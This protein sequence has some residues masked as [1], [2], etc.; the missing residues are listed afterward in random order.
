MVRLTVK[1]GATVVGA[2]AGVLVY[3]DFNDNTLGTNLGG[4]AGAMSYD[5]AHDPTLSFVPGYEGS[6]LRISYSVPAGQWCGYWSFFLASQKGY[7][8]SGFTDIRMWV[9]GGAGG[10]NFKIELKDF[11]GR[12][13]HVYVSI[14]PGF[15][16]GLS[17]S[18]QEL[19]IPLYNF[20]GV[21]LRWLRQVNIVFDTYPYSGTVYIDRIAFTELSPRTFAPLGLVLDDFNSGS[22]PNRLGGSSGTIDPNPDDPAEWITASYVTDS[23]EG[24]GALKLAYNR[25]T[26]SWVGYWTYM[27]PDGSGYDVSDYE[28]IS[29]YVKGAAGG[30]NFKIELVDTSNN[31]ATKYVTVP[32][33]SYQKVSLPFSQFSNIQNVNLRSLKQVNIVFDTSPNTGTVYI[34]LIRFEWVFYKEVAKRAFLYFWFEANPETGLV[35]D[36]NSDSMASIAATGFGLSAICV[37][38]NKGW[39][40]AQEA[41]QRVLT[42]LQFLRDNVQ[43]VNGMPY[44]FVWVH[45]GQRYGYSEIS[46][47]DT[48]IL[49]AGVLHA[50]NHFSDNSQIVSLAKELF[51]AVDWYWFVRPSGTFAAM[52]TPE[53]GFFGERF[54]YDEYMIAGILGLGSLTYP[55]PRSSWDAWRSAYQW[56]EYENYWFLCPAGYMRPCAYL[57][58]F[59]AAW[60]D[61]RDKHDNYVDYWEMMWNALAANR[62]YCRDWAENYP[63]YDDNL[64]GWTACEGPTGYLGWDPFRGTIAPSAVAGSL[65]FMPDNVIPDLWYI[66]EHYGDNIWSRYGFKDSMDSGYNSGAG[67]FAENSVGINKGPEVLLVEA[68]W[69]G[70]V[71]REFMKNFN[72]L[73]GLRK[74]GFTWRIY[75]SDDSYVDNTQPNTNFGTSP[76]LLVENTA[77]RSRLA[78]LKFDLSDVFSQDFGIA[79]ARLNVFVY[80]N[81]P[82]L[83]VVFSVENDAWSENTI[84]WNS[85]P[86]FQENIGNA[87]CSA[88]W[89]SIDITRWVKSQYGSDRKASVAVW[90]TQNSASLRS[91]EYT[92]NRK[93]RPFLSVRFSTVR[94]VVERLIPVADAYTDFNDPNTA[95]GVQN[96]KRLAVSGVSNYYRRSY[97]K[98]DTSS[99]P[100][101]AQILKARLWVY[102]NSVVNP[103]NPVKTIFACQLSNDAWQENTITWNNQPE[104][105]PAISENSSIPSSG[106]VSWDVTSWVLDQIS[107]DNVVSIV[108][109]TYEPASTIE[110]W[111]ESK[112]E[113]FGHIPYLEV[114]YVEEHVAP[115]PQSP[116]NN[117]K[118]FDN[119]PTFTWLPA[120]LAERHRLQIDNDP[121][122]TSPIYDN[123]NLSGSANQCTIENQLPADNYYWRVGA[124]VGGE[125]LWSGAMRLEIIESLSLILYPTH[126]AKVESAGP[127][128]NYNAQGLAA[129][130]PNPAYYRRSF[131]KF[132][133]SGI[134]PDGS[135][136]SAYLLLYKDGEGGGGDTNR[137][138]GAYRVSDDSWSETTITWNNQPSIGSLENY[139]LTPG[140]TGFWENWNVA[141]WADN[142]YKGDRILT[143]AIRMVDERTDWDSAEPYWRDREYSDA[144]Y[145]PRLVIT[146][147]QA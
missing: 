40:S 81:N 74:A 114:V 42:T 6:A 59:P 105:G 130:G 129:A 70:M 79:E 111:F 51:D 147:R 37:G 71:W 124:L 116:E 4:A 99:L 24:L 18:W 65:P 95:K 67:W 127:D 144:A 115:V 83:M 109:R 135:V 17:T 134:P 14:V 123:S 15:E 26:A 119:T 146:V 62:E 63:E 34:D 117:S 143:I 9:K 55:L 30:E 106:W 101:G 140:T 68:Y 131:L 43:K 113:L 139:I 87:T 8:V 64:W 29:F 3:D 98:F 23:Y 72:A 89:V 50:A 141:S 21:N 45:N 128:T 133:L 145:R 90:I 75:P 36:K 27:R 13:R 100:S 85:R 10:E 118:T 44:H 46:I 120:P 93:Q 66:Y 96:P 32:G 76:A 91:D 1:F 78:Y 52:W 92:D 102:V 20:E 54:G 77:S 94:P 82:G 60:I 136:A 28:N 31:V 84:T 49:M 121:T 88:G 48:A 142:Q 104:N 137:S 11:E 108:L 126:D 5:G 41:K 33:T 73:E 25:G 16:S 39:I 132:D 53:Q 112:E 12:S 107:V 7:D 86:A 2:K 56:A 35:P 38:E 122:F 19:V 103:G 47:V 110:P 125:W 57:Y 58:H 97:L 69:S 61:F 22:V 80:E 138:V